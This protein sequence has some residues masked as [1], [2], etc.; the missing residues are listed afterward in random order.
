MLYSTEGMAVNP[1]ESWKTVF[2]KTSQRLGSVEC[3]YHNSLQA[4][5]IELDI[6]C[7][8]AHL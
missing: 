4:S 5:F 8:V 2:N 6:Q 1:R 3:N 7:Q